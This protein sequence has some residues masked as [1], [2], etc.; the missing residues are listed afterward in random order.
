MIATANHDQKE[1]KARVPQAV[2][3]ALMK[4]R[5]SKA[6]F[7]VI[8]QVGYDSFRTSA[9]SKEAGVSQGAQ[10]HHFPTKDSLAVAAMDYAYRSSMD[11]FRKN[12]A[13]DANGEDL[14]DLMLKDFKDF[15]LSDY[16]M[17][18]LDILLACSKNEEL[19]TELS[20]MASINRITV[21]RQWLER[22]VN[23]GWTLTDAEDVMGLSHSIIRGF[24]VRGLL[25][26]SSTNN[27]KLLDRWKQMVKSLYL[28]K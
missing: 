2:R 13:V 1:K 17:V 26:R 12:F 16:F 15:Y 19:Q 20:E 3:S 25:K 27:E 7:N 18:A 6:A 21:E 28:D 9:V 22:L 11:Q 14:I 10:L 5:L 23:D 4:E 24:Y 8:R